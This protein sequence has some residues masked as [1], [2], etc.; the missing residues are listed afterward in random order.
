MRQF[1]FRLA[2]AL[3]WPNPDAMLSVMPQRVY[4][5]W[6]AYAEIDPW[7]EE[8]AD[9]RAAMV[10][11]TMANMWRGKK[12]RK[13]KLKDFMPQFKKRQAPRLKTPQQALGAMKNLASL[14]GGN[15]QDNRPE[16]KKKRDGPI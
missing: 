15:I 16:W 7:D 9:W 6:I 13:P 4:R 10:A 5:E 1:E 14:F 2:L 11:F 8:R 12:G 3:G